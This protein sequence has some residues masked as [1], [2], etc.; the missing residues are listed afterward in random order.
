[1][2]VSSHRRPSRGPRKVYTPPPVSP[3]S[4]D[5]FFDEP[6]VPSHAAGE[7]VAEEKPL[8]EVRKESTK[9]TRVAALLGGLIRR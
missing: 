8:G 7:K 6:Y 2:D 9:K 3:V 5:P 4:S 1:M